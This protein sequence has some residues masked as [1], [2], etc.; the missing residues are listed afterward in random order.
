MGCSVLLLLFFFERSTGSYFDY[1]FFNFLER[2]PKPVIPN[3]PNSSGEC[4]LY[5]ILSQFPRELVDASLLI[6]SISLS[7][8]IHFNCFLVNKASFS[9]Y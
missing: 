5:G 4:Y 2:E 7:H 8:D 9:F 6:L 3:L 1:N